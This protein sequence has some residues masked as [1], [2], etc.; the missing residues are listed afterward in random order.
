M[1]WNRSDLARAV[2]IAG[3]TL[4]EAAVEMGISQ[5]TIYRVV[6]GYVPR[7]RLIREAV[8]QYIR[9]HRRRR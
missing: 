6:K 4:A 3:Q 7:S 9:D 2:S 5:T 8:A 1:N